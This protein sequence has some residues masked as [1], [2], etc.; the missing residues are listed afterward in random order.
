MFAPAANGP[1][2]PPRSNM[3]VNMSYGWSDVDKGGPQES[4][5]N[6]FHCDVVHHKPH[7]DRAGSI[8][9]PHTE[10]SVIRLLIYSTSL[11]E[12]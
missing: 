4:K 8:L 10:R 9:G 5:R 6:L 11:G 7:S 3:R 2:V 12:I 1:I